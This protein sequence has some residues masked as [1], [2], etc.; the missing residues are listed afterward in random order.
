MDKY[1][2][3]IETYNKISQQYHDK[4]MD[5]T[6]YHHSYNKLLK[7]TKKAHQ[8]VLDVASGPVN[9]TKY[10]LSSRNDFKILGIDATEN[11]IQL[12][13]ENVPNANF[14]L[15][16]CRNIKN[17]HQKFD[18]I[19]FGFCFPYISKEESVQLINEAYSCLNK[20]GIL[21]ISTMIGDYDTDSV[22]KTSFDGKNRMFIH[23]HNPEYLIEA[24]QDNKFQLLENYTKEYQEGT[25]KGDTD[26][27]LIAKK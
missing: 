3:I 21:Y 10:L 4:F 12:A 16:D 14:K 2:N 25:I 26:L 19:V 15:L 17:L 5:A 1:K 24:I 7:H 22:F 9:I 8:T 20:N 23:Y 18:I 27:F 11:M 6:V 13:K